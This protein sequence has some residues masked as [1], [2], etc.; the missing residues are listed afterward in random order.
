MYI[1]TYFLKESMSLNDFMEQ[2]GPQALPLL[3]GL[4]V[5]KNY[6][7]LR[8]KVLCLW[9]AEGPEPGIEPKP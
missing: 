8:E 3:I 1:Y 4:S 5:S 7:F 2:I 9:Q 6:T